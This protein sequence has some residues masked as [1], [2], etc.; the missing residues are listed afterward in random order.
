MGRPSLGTA[1]DSIAAQRHAAIEVVL[2]AAAGH[3]HPQ[4]PSHCGRHPIRFVRSEQRLLRPDAAN[5]GLDAATGDWITFLDDDDR[6]LPWHV[7]GL[8]EAA[9]A[10]PEAMVLYSLARAVFADGT[11]QSFGQPFCLMQLYERN[12]IH[13]ST[14]LIARSPRVAGCRF[15]SRL[16]MHE[17][18]DFFLQLAHCVPL[19]FVPLQSFEW[20]ADAGESGGGG[21]RNH[22]AM[23]FASLRD[24]VYEKWATARDALID[25]VQEL[26]KA[27][28]GAAQRG[29]YALAR[30]SCHR[31]LDI[32]QNDPYALNVL[33]SVDRLSGDLPAARRVLAI[34]L[35]V[36]PQDASLYYNMALLCRELADRDGA[37]AAAGRAVVLEPDNLQYL[38]LQAALRQHA[39]PAV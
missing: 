22:D 36:R 16:D 33:A 19:H 26:L 24:Q 32:S 10:V 3:A 38:Q 12:F 34:A 30:A 8:V 39:A 14:A 37:V 28:V 11:V 35:A 18:W 6:I 2:V 20:H 7:S 23:K 1:L 4:P 9:H 21:G 25:Q 5:A 15:D 17:D 31:V 29:D 27:S 13:L